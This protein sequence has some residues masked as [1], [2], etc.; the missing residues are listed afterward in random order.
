VREPRERLVVFGGV[1][2]PFSRAGT[3]T[4][5]LS[6]ADLA[7][8]AIRELL[9]RQGVDGK[10][11]DEVLLGCVGP[12]AGEANV[13][14][15]AALR[16]GIP[17]RVP[18]V[19]V[20]RNCASGFESLTAAAER[21][22]ADQGS[23]FVAGGTES[24]SNY[25][26][27]LRREVGRTL[28]RT[29]RAK[30]LPAKAAALARLRPAALKPRVTLVEGLTDPV[31]GMIMGR[32]AERLALDFGISREEQDRF[33]CESHRRAEKARESGRLAR[34]I[35]PVFALD[36]E[37]REAPRYRAVDHDN[38]I[39][40]GQTL[41]ALARLRPYFDRVNG[42]VTVGNSSQVTDGACALLVGSEERGRS[43]GLRPLGRLLAHAYAGCE[44]SRMGLGPAYATPF[45]LD[46]A[47]VPFDRI[48]LVELN[49]AFAAQVLACQRAFASP[50]FARREFGRT[51]PIGAIDPDRLNVNGGA[52]ALG[53]PVGATGSR[54]ALTLLLEMKERDV[55]LGL[56][57]LCVGGGQGGALLFERLG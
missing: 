42:T 48:G 56:A 38:G 12:D 21:L 24:M 45:A 22:A 4:A 36:E 7:V 18:A 32:T 20:S 34:E 8:V 53:H 31:S 17:A 14:R 27:Q 40:P 41:E 39:R 1:R 57:T 15:V 47:G 16:A 23:L 3:E 52:I 51:S 13:A 50:D 25:P 30:G 46:R 55:P 5:S 44:P 26:L 11:I 54:L 29:R 28:D 37:A 33:A 2:T 43:L 9:H 6:A 19:T 10:E 49:E 35:V